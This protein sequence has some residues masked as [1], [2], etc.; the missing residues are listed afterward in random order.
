MAYKFD[1]SVVRSKAQYDAIQ[2]DR[3]NNPPPTAFQTGKRLVQNSAER[4]TALPR[5]G[6][7]VAKRA[8]DFGTQ[9]KP[10]GF[11]DSVV[12]GGGRSAAPVALSDPFTATQGISD[13]N[14]SAITSRGG[15]DIPL[16]PNASDQGPMRRGD[17]PTAAIVGPATP[18]RVFGK[19]DAP[20]ML[21]QGEYPAGMVSMKR[22]ADGSMTPTRTIRNA[23]MT[24]G[25]AESKGLIAGQEGLPPS[26]EQ[27]AKNRGVLSRLSKQWASDS[28]MEM[29]SDAAAQMKGIFAANSKERSGRTA[30]AMNPIAREQARARWAQA[31]DD[32]YLAALPEK[33]R[34]E[35]EAQRAATAMQR[36]KGTEG[37]QTE[38]LRAD[39]Q[40]KAGQVVT[41]REDQ[42]EN[43]KEQIEREKMAL[44]SQDRAAD[45]VASKKTN[46]D[47]FY[48]AY[49]AFM[50]KNPDIDDKAHDDFVARARKTYKMDG[51]QEPQ[52]QPQNPNPTGNKVSPANVKPGA[53]QAKAKAS[54]MIEPEGMMRVRGPS[55]KVA[56][57]PIG[58]AEAFLKLD[59][60]S[61]ID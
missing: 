5:L 39:A 23:P 54:G 26:A 55:G 17:Y 11:D 19:T 13:R 46:E 3:R 14:A 37:Y 43:R 36:V 33:K 20:S 40:V 32:A 28:G 8:I 10:T 53:L 4:L 45:R 34:R 16:D 38:K 7:R 60:Y 52:P 58:Q 41:G 2:E 51:V 24:L 30:V 48:D 35:V 25:E 12:T 56:E 1:D 47:R 9:Y 57:L 59:G 18:A 21:P 15:S 50:A 29:T 44:M 42:R 49:N 31:Q 6:A 27:V 22:N 61:R